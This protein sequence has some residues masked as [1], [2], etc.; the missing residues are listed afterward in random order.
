MKIALINDTHFGARQESLHFNDYFFRFWDNVFFPYLEKNNIV[1]IVHLGDLVDRRKFINYVI[2]HR[3]KKDFF[4]RAY[5]KGHKIDCLIGNHDVPYRNTN[6]PNAQEELLAQFSN[7][8]VYADPQEKVYDGLR[9]A[10]VP[11]INSGNYEDSIE[12]IKNTDCPV[13]FG[14]LEVSGFEMDK[15]HVCDTGLNRSLF[16]KFQ[17]AISG[18]F[19]TKSTDGSIFYLGSQ[20]EMT[21]SD[22]DDPK[23]FHVFDTGSLELQFIQN[24]YKMF[25]KLWYDDSKQDLDFWKSEDLSFYKDTYI[26]VVITNKNNPFLFDRVMDM[27]YKAGPIDIVIAEDYGT[28]YEDSTEMVNSAEDTP[29][30]INKHIDSLKL[31]DID[32]ERIK[33]ITR[34]L[35]VEALGMERAVD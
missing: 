19:H 1:Q 9:V 10:M 14:H 20:Y 25:H 5:Y 16:D 34:E 29:T 4:E 27:L 3:M 15:G 22:W 2:A 26:K 6:H 18:H 17:M 11:W 32:P 31:T 8:N 12:F 24:P 21:W 28:V 33:K 23:G 30:I 7:V 35:Y 13:L